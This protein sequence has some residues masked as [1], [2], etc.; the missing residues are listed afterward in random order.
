MLSNLIHLTNMNS[1][2]TTNSSIEELGIDK[3][4]TRPPTLSN[5]FISWISMQLFLTSPL[6]PELFS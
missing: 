1:Q 6:N 5:A 4:K 3:N 2:K